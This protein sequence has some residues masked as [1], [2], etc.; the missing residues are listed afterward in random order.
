MLRFLPS[1]GKLF[2]FMT[3]FSRPKRFCC[4][5]ILWKFLFKFLLFVGAILDV[6]VKTRFGVSSFFIYFHSTNY[7]T[8]EV[9]SKFNK[10]LFSKKGGRKLMMI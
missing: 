6:D 3:I 4:N 7:I 1:K 8:I 2:H 10:F 9:E 5:L